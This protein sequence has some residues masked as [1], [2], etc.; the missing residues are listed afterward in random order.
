M[1]FGKTK[2]TT[3]PPPSASPMCTLPPQASMML[4]VMARPVRRSTTAPSTWIMARDKIAIAEVS[5]RFNRRLRRGVAHRLDGVHVGA[6]FVDEVAA[7]ICSQQQDHAA[8]NT[9]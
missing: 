3:V 9:D 8:D 7:M 4:R 5:L 2:V 1:A 6:D